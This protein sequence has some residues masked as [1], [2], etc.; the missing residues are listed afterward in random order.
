M[1]SAVIW[2]YCIKE[3][4]YNPINGKERGSHL[5][6]KA[7]NAFVLYPCILSQRIK[8]LC[9]ILLQIGSRGSFLNTGFRESM[10]NWKVSR[11][12]KILL[13]RSTIGIWSSFS[14]VIKQ[15]M[16]SKHLNIL[17][18]CLIYCCK[19]FC[20]FALLVSSA[21]LQNIDLA[22]DTQKVSSTWQDPDLSAFLIAP[23]PG[24]HQ[25]S[26]MGNDMRGSC[27]RSPLL[28]LIQSLL[29]LHKPHKDIVT[30]REFDLKWSI[31]L[32]LTAKA[33]QVT[34]VTFLQDFSRPSS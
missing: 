1:Y 34:D 3:A 31:S 24:S 23:P 27:L 18:I 7:E 11:F 5:T 33:I 29:F 28:Y 19:N 32:L 9:C 16:E 6:R 30:V 15:H 8:I 21:A 14:E 26:T 22:S 20:P 13:R 25:W 12:Q 2:I 17:K 10:R 4:I